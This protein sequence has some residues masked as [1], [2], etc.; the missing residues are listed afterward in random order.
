MSLFKRFYRSNQGAEEPK[1]ISPSP[2]ALA[3]EL[4]AKAGDRIS[5]EHP[6]WAADR[7]TGGT[8]PE[9]IKIAMARQFARVLGSELGRNTPSSSESRK[10]LS[11]ALELLLRPAAM[12]KTLYGAI[13]TVSRSGDYDDASIHLASYMNARIP[14]AN[15]SERVATV[16]ALMR[17]SVEQMCISMLTPPT[18]DRSRQTMSGDRSVCSLFDSRGI[19]RQVSIQMMP[20]RLAQHFQVALDTAQTEIREKRATMA[21]AEISTWVGDFTVVLRVGEASSRYRTTREGLIESYYA[22]LLEYACVSYA[23]RVRLGKTA[24]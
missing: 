3:E 12:G 2:V 15:L 17:E 14:E 9:S 8:S 10:C 21:T 20:G 13:E 23:D 6:N 24:T 4:L 16:A 1:A 5:F 19:V 11:A 18:N 7:I 22:A